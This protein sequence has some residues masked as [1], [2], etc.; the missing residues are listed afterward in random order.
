MSSAGVTLNEVKGL[1]FYRDSSPTA[2][3]DR[4]ESGLSEYNLVSYD[5]FDYINLNGPQD[6]VSIFIPPH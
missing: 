5:P 2:Q 3:N 1:G 4:V 6:Q